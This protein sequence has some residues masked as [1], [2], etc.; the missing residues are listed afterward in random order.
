MAAL[1]AEARGDPLPTVQNVPIENAG[2]AT[3]AYSLRPAGDAAPAASHILD[4]GQPV[5]AG[6]IDTDVHVLGLPMQD[7]A[8][9]KGTQMVFALIWVEIFFF[10][11]YV[12]A[13]LAVGR[14]N[15][16]MVSIFAALPLCG[17]FGILYNSSNLLRC[18][19]CLSLLQALVWTV[20]TI[21]VLLI[22]LL[23]A[24]ADD[25]LHQDAEHV[26]LLIFLAGSYSTMTYY[27]FWLA[28][29]IKQ[30]VV[31]PSKRNQNQADYLMFGMQMM[32]M[33]ILQEVQ[34]L[35][36]GS[37]LVFFFMLF[38]GVAL[39]DSAVYSVAIGEF[40][41][42]FLYCTF[43]SLMACMVHSAFMGV[44]KNDVKLLTRSS[45][46]GSAFCFIFTAFAF[47]FIVQCGLPC[48]REWFLL[49]YIAFAF[50]W[51]ALHSWKLKGRV[52]AGAQLTRSVAEPVGVTVGTI[53]GGQTAAP[54]GVDG[55]G[56][57]A[58]VLQQEGVVMGRA[59]TE[60]G[61]GPAA[62]DQKPPPV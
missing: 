6:H 16:L 61:P 39:F 33:Q 3:P 7:P 26:V 12:A 4:V 52:E 22:M 57:P 38:L 55:F 41:F 28:E 40:I 31:L 49:L 13:S 37:W 1:E 62:A 21:L 10:A 53:V 59:L 32:D 18:F 58:N 34:N 43:F 11:E 8:I 54:V 19:G 35:F 29:K 20:V 2:T 56:G 23:T 17:Y 42:F 5:A 46:I 44:K 24:P 36:N 47:L 50:F 27:G 51:S 45:S 14:I 25:S 9:L 48:F 30:G 60:A 15:L